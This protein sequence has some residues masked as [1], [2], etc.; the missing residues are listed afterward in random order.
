MK[1]ET[2][3]MHTNTN[4]SFKVNNQMGMKCIKLRSQFDKIFCGSYKE[5]ALLSVMFKVSATSMHT[6]SCATSQSQSQ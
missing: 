1:V 6:G 4:S 3:K 5:H 2:P